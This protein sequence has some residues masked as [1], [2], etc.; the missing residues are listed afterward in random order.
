GP[1]GQRPG[2]DG[3]DPAAPAERAGGSL[4]GRGVP[5]AAQ[6]GRDPGSA[7]CRGPKPAADVR[8]TGAVNEPQETG[9][10]RN[11]RP[12]VAPGPSK[13]HH[14]PEYTTMPPAF[15]AV[16]SSLRLAWATALTPSVA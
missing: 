6:R 11:G 3:D 9:A 14:S 5:D 15:M 12:T 10:S 13:C 4:P 16:R 8:P 7:L 2:L 1:A